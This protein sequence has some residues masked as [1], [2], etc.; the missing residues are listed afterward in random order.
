M[1]Q[2]IMEKYRD[3]FKALFEKRT[4]TA[5]PETD[6]SPDQLAAFERGW[7]LGLRKG[8]GNG[9]VDGVSVVL[10]SVEDG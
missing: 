6:L 8:Y 7:S 3:K 2:I 4:T 10:S 1:V 5:P 9:L